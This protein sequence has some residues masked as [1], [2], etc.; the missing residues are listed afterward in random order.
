MKRRRMDRMRENA[1][2]EMKPRRETRSRLWGHY[3]GPDRRRAASARA[4]VQRE[5]G[6]AVRILRSTATLDRPS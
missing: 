5:V 3:D 4:R 1:S 2:E 6:G